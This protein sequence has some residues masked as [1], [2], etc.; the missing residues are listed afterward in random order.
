MDPGGLEMIRMR[1]KGGPLP[2][3]KRGGEKNYFFFFFRA[4]MCVALAEI[5]TVAPGGV[6]TIVQEG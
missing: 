3:E 2:Q 4:M 5:S 6:V 1:K